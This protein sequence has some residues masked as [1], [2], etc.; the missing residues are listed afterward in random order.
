MPPEIRS[1]RR[2]DGSWAQLTIHPRRIDRQQ[3]VKGRCVT[4]EYTLYKT[5]EAVKT[6]ASNLTH[7]IHAEKFL[8]VKRI[9]RFVPLPV[10]QWRDTRLS[11]K[12]R[13]SALRGPPTTP[14]ERMV[15]RLEA[16]PGVVLT[17]KRGKPAT[18]KALAAAEQQ[19]GQ[20]LPPSLRAFLAQH[21]GLCVEWVLDEHGW[22]VAF[23]IWSLREI[24]T[25]RKWRGATVQIKGGLLLPIAPTYDAP[26]LGALLRGKGEAKI[27]E[28][29]DPPDGERYALAPT[30]AA[31]VTRAVSTFFVKTGRHDVSEKW[32]PAMR[33]VIVR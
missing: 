31:F 19:L 6:A 18:A 33:K 9:A 23:E 3:G 27:I 12:P 30:F 17:F 7:A 5:P 8:R 22:Q 29:L 11:V 4:A 14:L 15:A 16:T 24:L 2:K 10:D 32:L 26:V 25:E 13:K 28:S 1:F 21:D 20:P